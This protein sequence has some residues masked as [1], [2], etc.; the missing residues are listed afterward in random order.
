[1]FDPNN[2]QMPPMPDMSQAED[3]VCERC[4]GFFFDSVMMV[5]K[6]SALVSPSG[7]Q[8]LMP[9]PV[10]RCA[11]CKFINHSQFDPVQSE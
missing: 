11:E 4:G 10:F 8:M 1:M 5:K 9:Q 2:P 3:Y 7:Q 6:L